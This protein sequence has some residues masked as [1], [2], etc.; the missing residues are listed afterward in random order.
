[1]KLWPD[2]GC[3]SLQAIVDPPLEAYKGVPTMARIHPSVSQIS[4]VSHSLTHVLPSINLPKFSMPKFSWKK[5]QCSRWSCKIFNG[6]ASDWLTDSQM[7]G[8]RPL[9][10]HQTGHKRLT[11]RSAWHPIGR[12]KQEEVQMSQK[13]MRNHHQT[14]EWMYRVPHSTRHRPW[15]W[16]HTYP[17]QPR[18]NPQNQHLPGPQRVIWKYLKHRQVLASFV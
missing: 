6:K 15:T 14:L 17:T 1:M 7:D 5:N 8:F 18:R 10:D 13:C 11:Q 2:A 4:P 3:K 16:D 12:G 9:W